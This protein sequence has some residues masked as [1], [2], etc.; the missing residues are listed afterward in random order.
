[1]L[2]VMLSKAF[3]LA[4]CVAVMA[5]SPVDYT[6]FLSNSVCIPLQRMTS[7][8]TS[9][10]DTIVTV[11][12]WP[13]AAVNRLIVTILAQLVDLSVVIVETSI[14]FLDV[15]L[16]TMVNGTCGLCRLAVNSLMYLM[17]VKSQVLEKIGISNHLEN[18]NPDKAYAPYIYKLNPLLSSVNENTVYLLSNV[19]LQSVLKRAL[20]S[21][22]ST[23]GWL[24]QTPFKIFQTTL[25]TCAIIVKYLFALPFDLTCYSVNYLVYT[26]MYPYVYMVYSS[27]GVGLV[28]L[29]L[30]D[31]IRNCNISL[32]DIRRALRLARY[33]PRSD[34]TRTNIGMDG[35][36]T[37]LDF[38]EHRVASTRECV[39][40]YEVKE[41][42]RLRPCGHN[43][44][45]PACIIH[46]QMINNRCPVCRR[47]ILTV[48]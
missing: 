36:G 37:V 8:V 17:S 47:D 13:F 22:V 42:V 10:F 35:V 5:T 2:S 46:I 7:F 40:C 23:V 1:M 30:P 44:V 41:L 32:N 26:G 6:V 43:N 3:V 12:I 38:L 28:A 16:R 25:E 9:S 21:L 45:C 34:E 27:M 20:V 4:A 14:Y 39:V 33:N 11:L 19:F 29:I 15:C 18:V 48:C 31:L 24:L